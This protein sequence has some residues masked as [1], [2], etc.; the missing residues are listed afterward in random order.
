MEFHVKNSTLLMHSLKNN[1][2]VTFLKGTHLGILASSIVD[3]KHHFSTT[4]EKLHLALNSSTPGNLLGL[5]LGGII[6]EYLQLKLL[7]FIGVCFIIDGVTYTTML[8]W[9]L[10]VFG[11]FNFLFGFSYQAKDTG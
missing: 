8:N 1:Q 3:L 4:Y 6:S 5:L 11:I 9:N 10:T 2:H 7:Y